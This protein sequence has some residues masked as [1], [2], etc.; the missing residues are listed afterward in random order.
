MSQS[1]FL[2][3]SYFLLCGLTLAAETVAGQ[4][5]PVDHNTTALTSYQE[6]MLSIERVKATCTVVAIFVPLLIGVIALRTQTKTTFEI[7]AAELVMQSPT[8]WIAKQRAQVIERMFPKRL[9]NFARS[10]D[11][12]DFP[13]TR[14]HEMKIEL[15]R[16]LA[17]NPEERAF[18]VA[19]WKKQFPKDTQ[20][21]SLD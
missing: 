7:K 14:L 19:E 5:A 21:F 17:V 9:K 15:I 10:F 16:L 3:V 6:E 18:I 1:G 12:D 2:R 13:G 11:F 4:S 20:K 8:P